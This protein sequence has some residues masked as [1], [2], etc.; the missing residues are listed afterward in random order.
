LSSR[1]V[2]ACIARARLRSSL[3]VIPEHD[4]GTILRSRRRGDTAPTAGTKHRSGLSNC[5]QRRILGEHGCSCPVAAGPMGRRDVEPECSTIEITI[6]SLICINARSGNSTNHGELAVCSFQHDS[7]CDLVTPQLADLYEARIG[8][9]SS[10]SC[11]D[12]CAGVGECGQQSLT[13]FH[14]LYAHY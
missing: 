12:R 6:G 1:S 14:F 11:F 8:L 10:G 3:R 9:K 4:A 2:P 13:G 5:R 7:H